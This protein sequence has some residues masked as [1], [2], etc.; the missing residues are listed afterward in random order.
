MRNRR[1]YAKRRETMWNKTKKY[2]R[3]WKDERQCETGWEN[4]KKYERMLSCVKRDNHYVRKENENRSTGQMRGPGYSTW[5][6]WALEKNQKLGAWKKTKIGRLKKRKSTNF[7]SLNRELINENPG[8]SVKP[9]MFVNCQAHLCWLTV[10]STTY[11]S[12]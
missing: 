6:N 8:M 12:E 9:I 4:M 7:W 3:R 1:N 11:Q 10:K 2:E 5:R